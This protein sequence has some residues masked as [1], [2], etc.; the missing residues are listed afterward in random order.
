MGRHARPLVTRPIGG[1]MEVYESIWSA[2][3]RAVRTRSASASRLLLGRD[4]PAEDARLQPRPT[5]R[6]ESRLGV[7]IGLHRNPLALR[8]FGLGQVNFEDAVVILGLDFVWIGA[9]RQG[10]DSLQMPFLE[11]TVAFLLCGFAFLVGFDGQQ[12]AA[13]AYLQV[14]GF[15]ARRLS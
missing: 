11:G 9:G 1:L 7:R 13:D 14:F 2:S 3:N 10:H 4:V 8:V 6:F 5:G 12:V 15:E